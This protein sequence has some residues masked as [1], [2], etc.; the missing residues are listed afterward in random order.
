M[1]WRAPFAPLFNG[2]L[3]CCRVR[4][5][6]GGSAVRGGVARC[7]AAALPH[8]VSLGLHAFP[9]LHPLTFT[10][11]GRGAYTGGSGELRVR[12]CRHLDCPALCGANRRLA[13]ALGDLWRRAVNALALASPSLAHAAAPVQ[14]RPSQLFGPLAPAALDFP[15]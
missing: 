15:A 13:G 11:A 1:A 3:Q 10:S 9:P 5:S 4:C 2:I 14:T 6:K 8:H 7:R 12:A